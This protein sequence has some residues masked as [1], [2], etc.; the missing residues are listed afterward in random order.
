VR[1]FIRTR[2]R[3]T[4]V[5][6][7][8]VVALL[9]MSVSLSGCKSFFDK[10]PASRAAAPAPRVPTGAEKFAA[11]SDTLSTSL[12]A[13]TRAFARGSSDATAIAAVRSFAADLPKLDKGVAADFAKT[14]KILTKVKS[15]DKDAIQAKVERQYAERRAALASKLAAVTSAETTAALKSSIAATAD[16]LDSITP[17]EPYQ[18][19]GT[20]LPHRIVDAK[21]GP[22]VLGARI[23]PAYAANTPGA[24]PSTLPV[25]P[26]PEDTT[27]TVEVV[28]TPEITSLAASLGSDP[29]RMYEYVRNTIDFEP[30][31]G[32]R[33]GATETLLEGSGNDI[34]TASLLIALYRKAGIPARYVSGVVEVPIDKAMNW[35]GVETPEAAA[36]LF[37]AGGTPTK[38]LISGGKPKALQIEH[39]WADVYVDYEDYRGAGA[40]SGEKVWVPLDG[41][42][43]SYTFPGAARALFGNTVPAPSAPAT[44]SAAI[45]EYVHDATATIAS[46][47]ETHTA[48]ELAALVPHDIVAERV[49]VLPVALPWRAVATR[50][51]REC[52][53]RDMVS[54]ALGGGAPVMMP[55]ST[56][57]SATIQISYILPDEAALELVSQHGSALSVPAYL[58]EMTPVLWVDGSVVATGPVAYVGSAQD[59]DVEI[60]SSNGW[61]SDAGRSVFVGGVY[62]L[63]F[64]A[65]RMSGDGLGA[66]KGQ[67]QGAID[68][69]NTEDI[70]AQDL[71]R[72]LLGCVGRT[73]FAQLDTVT[74]LMAEAAGVVDIHAP[75]ALFA[76][77]DVSP[78]LVLGLPVAASPSGLS[79]DVRTNDH[80]VVAQSE[81]NTQAISRFDEVAGPLSSRLESEVLAEFIG[82]QAVSTVAVFAEAVRR[83]VEF[84]RLDADTLDT[85]LPKLD[86][87]PL[88]K[89]RIAE[90]V[91]SGR[92][93][94]LPSQSVPIGT[95]AGHAWLELDT[96]T[97]DTG[98]MID[99][100]AGAIVKW[101]DP[102]AGGFVNAWTLGLSAIVD[103][104]YLL[105]MKAAQGTVFSSRLTLVQ[106]GY[107]QTYGKAAGVVA[108]DLCGVIALVAMPL[109][110]AVQLAASDWSR[111]DLSTTA[112]VERVLETWALFTA[113]A[114][115]TLMLAM[116]V[117]SVFGPVMAAIVAAVV[118]IG[119]SVAWT[120]IKEDILQGIPANA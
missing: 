55:L 32:S 84:L 39:T 45:R 6:I 85:E 38:L 56:A 112:K 14:R 95:W 109:V 17:E 21:A 86:A 78:A 3:R 92:T 79:L 93:V 27:Q 35:V 104:P 88:F 30:Y 102:G 80:L 34:D 114:A 82:G 47:A 65:G 94:V 113:L 117:S 105:W 9:A 68:R 120:I 69:F 12:E 41:S 25:T 73:Y 15:P 50:E 96:A 103:A 10:Q 31:H 61:S 99:S 87:S 58:A 76:S 19:L 54:I 75:S 90:T 67:L 40:G 26:T 81:T 115:A 20:S 89:Q 5:G 60:A 63:T 71:T 8:L 59:V 37:S 16:Y 97:G 36:K 23:A 2:L 18:P 70:E 100:L 62:G 57:A 98:Y 118:S 83:G 64:D 119:I 116:A 28:F 7:P 24:T 42:F 72:P 43:K 74:S 33:K 13:A 11:A 110:A 51:F 29:V 53:T 107:I 77:I 48:G 22:P 66:A 4:L 106:Q 1:S 91:R 111:T 44:D 52:T 49:G 108:Y 101:E 46:W